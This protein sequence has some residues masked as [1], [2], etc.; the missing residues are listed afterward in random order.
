MVVRYQ[1]GFSTSS[2]STPLF[3]QPQLGGEANIR[4]VEAGEYIGRTLGF[5]QAEVGVNAESVWHWIH[6]PRG[7]P[8]TAAAQ[9]ET[10]VSA[11]ASLLSSLGISSIFID[12]LY[13]RGKVTASSSGSSLFDLQHAFH[14]SGIKGELRGLRVKNRRANIGLVYARS[15]ASVLHKKGA[16]LTTISMDF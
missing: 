1:R 4:G 9:S 3:E 8:T 12:A 16:F 10:T 6:E 7:S 2:A 14:G 5:D 13:D 15:A 11:K